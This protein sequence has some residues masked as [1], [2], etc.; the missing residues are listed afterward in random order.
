[1]ISNLSGI[2]LHESMN[3]RDRFR[4]IRKFYSQCDIELETDPN[5]IIDFFKHGIGFSHLEVIAWD[6]IVASRFLVFYPQYPINNYFVDF[7]NPD[8]K[9][10]IELDGA[11]WH[12]PIKDKKRD[13]KLREMGY[14]IFRIPGYIAATELSLN[15]YVQFD[16]SENEDHDCTRW[17][18]ETI[19]GFLESV[20]VFYFN[21]VSQL[22]LSTSEIQNV[23]D[24]YLSK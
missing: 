16:L 24:G 10:I 18:T 5:I 12:D 17:M 6:I 14:T 11:N 2:T 19:N 13:D 15:E 7:C 8:K 3:M 21:G 1:M 23:L 4:A 9:I 20:E 22:N